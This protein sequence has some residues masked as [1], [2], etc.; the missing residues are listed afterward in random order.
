MR[1]DATMA[2]PDLLAVFIY[3]AGG[4]LG[5]A[6]MALTMTDL[7]DHQPALRRTSNANRASRGKYLSARLQASTSLFIVGDKGRQVPRADPAQRH[8]AAGVEELTAT[9]RRPELHSR[10]RRAR[11]RNLLAVPSSVNC[12]QDVTNP[13]AVSGYP[14][15]GEGLF[16]EFLCVRSDSYYN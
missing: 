5:A 16:C 10:C 4:V 8:R 6:I 15:S 9:L 1:L 13:F 11:D 3:G 14:L 7:R 12:M 2:P